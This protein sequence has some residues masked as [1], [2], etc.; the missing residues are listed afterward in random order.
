MT[1]VAS[2]G[3]GV[4]QEPIPDPR[5]KVARSQA[6]L[7]L[8]QVARVV[9][10][11]LVTR[12]L[13]RAMDA[14]DFG[15]FA[16]VSTLFALALQVMDMGSTAVATRQIGQ[17]PGIQRELLEALLGWRLLLGALMALGCLLLALFGPAQ[18]RYERAVLAV[19]AIGFLLLHHSTYYVVFQLRQE[20]GKPLLL[21]LGSQVG[22]LLA[23]LLLL[24]MHVAGV[25]VAL[26]VVVREIVQ[27]WGSRLIAI[28]ALGYRLR[29]RLRSPAL[30]ALLRTAWA[31]GLCA[32]IYKLAFHGGTFFVWALEP[33]DA[34]GT[35][36]AT[37]RLFSPVIDTAWLFVTPLIVGMSVAARSDLAVFREQLAAYVCLLLGVAGL[38]A[39]C[40]YILAPTLLW[41]LYGDRYVLGA[42]SSVLTFQWFSAA[43]ALSLITPVP[44]IAMLAQHREKE[45]LWISAVGLGLNVIVCAWA[46]P[47]YG[48][49]GAGM[50]TFAT[51]ASILTGLLARL[52]LTGDWRLSP[53][54]AA[55]LLPAGLLAVALLALAPH[56]HLRLPMAVLV[57]SVSVL[58]M[59]MIPSQ[60]KRRLGIH[61]SA[62]SL[63]NDPP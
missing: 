26:L 4:I 18:D 5:P 12:Q 25:V 43:T 54:L 47:R 35:L 22:F 24:W 49:A 7:L 58:A 56:P 11:L 39:V 34:L 14:A 60:K 2:P 17:Q 28:R 55:H 6:Y 10:F 63:A 20:F 29:P 57:G 27:V 36:S 32:V 33:P 16:L 30:R 19:A 37:L 51:E 52:H 59:W 62:M 8:A 1:S 15:F 13:G 40:G 53:R 45:L 42:L 23:S 38:L 50:A 9:L 44:V 21:G 46:I 61:P 48:A 41:M 31:F 3:T